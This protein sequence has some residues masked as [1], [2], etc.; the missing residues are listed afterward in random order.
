MENWKNFLSEQTSAGC[1]RS[2]KH[3]KN[4]RGFMTTK[5]TR[6]IKHNLEICNEHPECQDSDACMWTSWA[7]RKKNLEVPWDMHAQDISYSS[8]SNLSTINIPFTARN[9]MKKSLRFTYSE[10]TKLR[11]KVKYIFDRSGA[12]SAYAEVTT[13]YDLDKSLDKYWSPYWNASTKCPSTRL[14]YPSAVEAARKK[15]SSRVFRRSRCMRGSTEYEKLKN[16]RQKY[17]DSHREIAYHTVSLAPVALVNTAKYFN[18]VL[19][20]NI[21]PELNNAGLQITVGQNSINKFVPIFESFVAAV[22]SVYLA[23]EFS[24]CV[25]SEKNARGKR[26]RFSDS[27]I[28]KLYVEG[29]LQD[30]RKKSRMEAI[31]R[32]YENSHEIKAR[33]DTVLFDKKLTRLVKKK[34]YPKLRAVLGE[35]WQEEYLRSLG[36]NAQGP[37]PQNTP[38]FKK[39][40]RIINTKVIPKIDKVFDFLKKDAL[41]Q[42]KDAEKPGWSYDAEK[43]A[44]NRQNQRT[45]QGR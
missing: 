23:H 13:A 26:K 2:P 37:A 4:G 45:R 22:M 32:S 10:R 16:A 17:F 42:L 33:R 18:Q 24:H 5:T 25:T 28:Q 34:L 40:K 35:W 30:P 14:G 38:G 6:G 27:Y 21:L 41:K 19:S 12:A 29:W 43:Q 7:A 9:I 11:K 31:M 36:S 3:P 15:I 8:Q 39:L 1:P 20:Q 44:L